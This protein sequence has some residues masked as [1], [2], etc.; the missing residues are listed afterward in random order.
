MQGDQ[1]LVNYHPD[2]PDSSPFFF[3]FFSKLL[4]SSNKHHILLQSI[5]SSSSN[6]G[7]KVQS[8]RHFQNNVF[9]FFQ[10]LI[11]KL[12]A[13]FYDRSFVF[14][15]ACIY[16]SISSSLCICISPPLFG[17]QGFSCWETAHRDNLLTKVLL[18]SLISASLLCNNYYHYHSLSY[19]F[20]FTLLLL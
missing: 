13:C 19:Y 12:L 20:R 4:S 8:R 6:L 14:E 1:P 2:Q 5:L 17:T 7:I 9:L 16:I 15:I 10:L 11:I 18:L 3:L